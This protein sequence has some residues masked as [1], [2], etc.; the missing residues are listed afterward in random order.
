MKYRNRQKVRI[1][2]V[3]IQYISL[4]LSAARHICGSL[5]TSFDIEYERICE[6]GTG[7]HYNSINKLPLSHKVGE[8]QK[9]Y[10]LGCEVKTKGEKERWRM[11]RWGQDMKQKK[12]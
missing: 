12:M 10:S 8:K 9:L 4:L 3:Q 11:R 2:Y 5:E 1:V 6:W 7:S